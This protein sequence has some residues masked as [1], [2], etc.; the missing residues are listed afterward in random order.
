MRETTKKWIDEMTEKQ[1]LRAYSRLYA[2]MEVQG[3]GGLQYGI[4]WPTLFAI[5]PEIAETMKTILVKGK[6]LSLAR[7]R[8]GEIQ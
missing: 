1:L 8:F 2:R 6:Q 4:D 3:A 7:R 5:S